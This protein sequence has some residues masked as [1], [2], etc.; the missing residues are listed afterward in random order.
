MK[1][2]IAVIFVA[3]LFTSGAIDLENAGGCICSIDLLT[4]WQDKC[5]FVDFVEELLWEGRHV[6]M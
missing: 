1:G 2:G 5:E 3:E 6:V 4:R